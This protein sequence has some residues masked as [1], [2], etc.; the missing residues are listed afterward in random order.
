[1]FSE[2][3]MLAR[4][5]HWMQRGESVG[6]GSGL[7]CVLCMEKVPGLI[8][9]IS[10]SCSSCQSTLLTFNLADVNTKLWAAL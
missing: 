8:C 6:E 3:S 10:S 7:E 1:M 5:G 4:W 2:S 9:G